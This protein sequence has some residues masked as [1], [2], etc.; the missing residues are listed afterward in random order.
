MLRTHLIDAHFCGTSGMSAVYLLLSGDG[1]AALVDCGTPARFDSILRSM[2]SLGAPP[3]RLSS[4]FLT[5]SHLDHSGNVSLFTRRFPHI[6]VHCSALT[7]E[8]VSSPER[9]CATMSHNLLKQWLSEFRGE[10]RPVPPRFFRPARA[11][12]RIPF[13]SS[14]SLRIVGAPGHSADHCVFVD[15]AGGTVFC[16]DAFGVRYGAVNPHRSLVSIPQGFEAAAVYR[17]LSEIGRLDVARAALGHFGFVEDLRAHAELC[18]RF[19]DRIMSA[20]RGAEK[21]ELEASLMRVYAEE[22]GKDALRSQLI[23]GN[24]FANLRGLTE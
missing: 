15:D 11:G 24:L 6:R 8:G 1:E 3:S 17:T 14:A 22:L 7:A 9:L 21:K 2:A 5:H 13:G 20:K 18:R 19:M 16:G 4:I 12:A 23:R 10:V